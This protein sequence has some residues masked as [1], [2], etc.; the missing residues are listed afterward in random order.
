MIGDIMTIS[1]LRM[2]TDGEGVSTLVTFFD[3]PLHCKYCANDF[4]HNDDVFGGVPRA[5]YTP[6]ELV[7]ILRKDDIYYKMSG[8][9]VVFGGGEP[10]LQSAFIHEVCKLTDPMWKKRI[11]TSLNVPWRC[12]EP[13]LN[14]IDEWIIDIKDMDRSIYKEYT[15]VDQH[16]LIDNLF[17]IRDHVDK[18]KLHIR[19]PRIQGINTEK[20]IEESVK[21]I[22]DVLK[23]EA[24][25][26]DY[27]IPAKINESIW[28]DDD[29]EV[30][31][32]E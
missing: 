32:D 19:V 25:V 14:D 16:Q 23:V 21:W 5:A 3:C 10:L 26:F 29:D 12:V 22:K 20:N 27:Y 13:V 9:G 24:E 6:E 31:D 11:E 17:R 30:E 2:G 15:G 8:G 1:R 7:K 18:S 28:D 4:C